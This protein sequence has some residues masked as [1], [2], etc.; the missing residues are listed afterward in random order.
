MSPDK[1]NWGDQFEGQP[2]P[3]KISKP[4]DFFT[5]QGLEFVTVKEGIS[6]VELNDLFE[7]VSA[8]WMP[9]CSTMGHR[10]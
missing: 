10:L 4:D 5:K 8:Q 7:K 9:A 6:L 3:P 1:T 2:T